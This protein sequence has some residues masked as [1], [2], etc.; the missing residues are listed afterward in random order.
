MGRH[1]IRR[2]RIK[3]P[4]IGWDGGVDGSRSAGGGCTRFRR[5][6]VRLIRVYMISLSRVWV[7]R[8]DGRR[9]MYDAGGDVPVRSARARGLSARVGLHIRTHG[10][11]CTGG[12]VPRA[13]HYRRPIPRR[14]IPRRLITRRWARGG[15][16]GGYSPRPSR[17]RRCTRRWSRAARV[18][19]WAAGRA[20]AAA[21]R[22]RRR[23]ECRTRGSRRR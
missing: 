8:S 6:S 7:A 21:A 20:C 22:A 18:G 14:P 23:G 9:V 10:V 16:D 12:S 2:H 4:G 5:L 19:A 15:R 11:E 3:R 17:R 1:G 13:I